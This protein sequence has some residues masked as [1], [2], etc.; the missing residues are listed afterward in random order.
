MDYDPAVYDIEMETDFYHY[1]PMSDSSLVIHDLMTTVT[2]Y[3]KTLTT[4]NIDPVHLTFLTCSRIQGVPLNRPLSILLDSGSTTSWLNH[5]T[6][7]SSISPTTVTSLQGMTM[8]GNFKSNQQLTLTSVALPELSDQSVPTFNL[9]MF[10]SSFRCDI[11]LGHDA[12]TLFAITIDFDSSKVIGCESRTIALC[13]FPH[14]ANM[15]SS[16]VGIFLSMDHFGVL[17]TECMISHNDDTFTS[18]PSDDL[19]ALSSPPEKEKQ[20]CAIKDSLY[21]KHEPAK[22]AAR[23][24]HLDIDQQQKLAKLLPKY[25]VLFNGEL[26]VYPHQQLHLDIDPSIKPHVSHAYPIARMQLNTFK[27]ELD[28]LC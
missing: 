5:N 10:N 22:I 18:D 15:S 4:T 11:I 7:P 16:D 13:P 6:L 24:T 17:L 3:T 28:C 26:K 20:K 23:C 14:E 25:P 27:K 19:H 9:N 1:C 8:A 21:E 12:L 2:A